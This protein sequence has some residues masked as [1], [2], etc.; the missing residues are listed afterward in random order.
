MFI[1]VCKGT[2]LNPFLRQVHFVKRWSTAEG[3]E[4]GAIQVGIDGFRAVAEGS[5]QYAGN[6]DPAYDGENEH[7]FQK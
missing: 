2:Q 3:R 6:D 7:S 5:G 4:V 1:Q